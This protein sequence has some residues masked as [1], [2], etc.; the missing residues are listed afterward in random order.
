MCIPKWIAG[1]FQINQQKIPLAAIAILRLTRG[2]TGGKS[3]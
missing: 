3:V 2:L 1:Q